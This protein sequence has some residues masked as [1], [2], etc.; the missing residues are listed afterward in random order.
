MNIKVYDY[1]NN[2]KMIEIPDDKKIESLD[3]AIL[4]GDETGYIF[5]TDGSRQKFDASDNRIM[6]F[7]DGFYTVP[8]KRVDAWLNWKPYGTTYSYERQDDFA[9]LDDE[10]D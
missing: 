6:S 9:Y 3:I 10:E 2:V 5:F 1:D 4:S 8:H 7:D